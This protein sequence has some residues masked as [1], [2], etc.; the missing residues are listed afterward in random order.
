M[1][2]I[3]MTAAELNAVLA[4]N[5][6]MY[7]LYEQLAAKCDK[8]SAEVGAAAALASEISTEAEGLVIGV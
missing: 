4:K 8:L 5:A 6:E 3:N 7:N 1:A 2:N